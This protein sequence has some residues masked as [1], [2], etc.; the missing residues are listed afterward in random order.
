ME[1]LEQVYSFEDYLDSCGMHCEEGFSFCDCFEMLYR[2]KNLKK[3]DIIQRAL[4]DRGYAHQMIRG[5]RRPTRDKVIMFALGMLL[6]IPEAQLLL[7]HSG[8][9]PLSPRQRRD[10]VALFAI[11][12]GLEVEALNAL[13]LENG[14][15]ILQ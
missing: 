5:I 8:F 15:E 7:R 13:L 3:M 2:Q 1:K 6:T 10:A 9:S 12:H 14:F 4:L 11:V